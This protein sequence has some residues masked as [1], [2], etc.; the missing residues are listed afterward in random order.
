[1]KGKEI[2]IPVGNVELVGELIVP[3]KAK[4]L[5]IFSHGSGSSRFGPRNNMVAEVL[6]NR[7]IGTLLF[8]LLTAEE[9]AVYTTHLTLIC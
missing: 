2:H 1:M 4:G 8:D 3:V 9:D 5:V 7:E 6:R